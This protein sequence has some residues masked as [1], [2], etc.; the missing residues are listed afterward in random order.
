M[1]SGRTMLIAST[2]RAVQE[3]IMIHLKEIGAGNNKIVGVQNDEELQKELC[4]WRP[5]Y[6]LIEGSFYREATP[7]EIWRL[8]KKYM[9]LRIFVFGFHE[10]PE[11]FLKCILRTGVDG[12]LDMRQGGSDFNK[13]LKC[14]LTGQMVIPHQLS[15]MSFDC[16]MPANTNNLTFRDME[17]VHLIIAG[18]ENS[19]IGDALH[20]KEQSVKNRRAAIYAKLQVTNTVGLLKQIIRRGLIDVDEFLAS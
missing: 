3:I 9:S 18:L 19:E 11:H 6:L 7:D 14:A 1:D 5:R 12:Y 16:I 2:S 13:D 8:M 4:K 10:Y 20:L 15:G 17:I